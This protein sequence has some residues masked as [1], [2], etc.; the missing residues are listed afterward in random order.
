MAVMNAPTVSAA[1]VNT[2]A[3]LLI[4]AAVAVDLWRRSKRASGVW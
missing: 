3:L 1:Q 2:S 4:V